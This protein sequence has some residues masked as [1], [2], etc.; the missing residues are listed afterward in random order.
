MKH[1]V[2]QEMN[3]SASFARQCM[4]ELSAAVGGIVLVDGLDQAELRELV[5]RCGRLLED[6]Q[7]NL[8][9]VGVLEGL[10]AADALDGSDVELVKAVAAG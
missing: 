5:N 8:D 6:A 2:E 1:L 9:Q 3:I 7:S 10:L 4:V